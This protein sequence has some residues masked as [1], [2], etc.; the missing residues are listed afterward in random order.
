MSLLY[1]ATGILDYRSILVR[2]EGIRAEEVVTVIMNNV[3][4][5]KNG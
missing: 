5:I 1:V 4:L 3:P 2:I